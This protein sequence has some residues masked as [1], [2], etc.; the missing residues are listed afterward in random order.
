MQFFYVPAVKKYALI[1]ASV[2][3]LITLLLLIFLP[4]FN[5]QEL[6]LHHTIRQKLGFPRMEYLTPAN[7][8]ITA[9]FQVFA[10]ICGAMIGIFYFKW[11]YRHEGYTLLTTQTFRTCIGIF[12]CTFL[13]LF[14][15][16]D[17]FNMVYPQIERVAIQPIARLAGYA[18]RTPKF[19]D[20]MFRLVPSSA[21]V[22]RQPGSNVPPPQNNP[23]PQTNP[24]PQPPSSMPSAG[25]LVNALNSYRTKNGRPALTQD[26]Y[27]MG[28]AQQR[29]QYYV[30]H[31]GLDNHEQFFKDIQGNDFN[32]RGYYS[33]GENSSY[34]GTMTAEKND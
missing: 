32:A 7:I 8:M 18:F 21:P 26:D 10:A 12:L 31:G 29:A 11:K 16:A 23:P 13:Y 1:G 30:S 15:Y 4:S 9:F 3:F 5:Y 25:E 34:S 22:Y 6:L 28:Y 33:L 2:A 17:I 20:D 19:N 24:E 14:L 27:L